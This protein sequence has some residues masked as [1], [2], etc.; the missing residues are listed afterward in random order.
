MILDILSLSVSFKTG[1]RK[2]KKYF[3]ILA[4]VGGAMLGGYI[5]FM[6]TREIG[7][8]MIPATGFLFLL[9][10]VVGWMIESTRQK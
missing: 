9:V 3:R 6:A 4:M 2:M 1:G 10:G 5:F 8:A 7:L